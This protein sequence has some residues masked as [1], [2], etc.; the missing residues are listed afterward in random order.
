[1]LAIY[2]IQSKGCI[3]IRHAHGKH[4]QT[5]EINFNYYILFVVFNS[6]VRRHSSI[7]RSIA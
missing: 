7:T 4:I 5:D 6:I 3:V 2:I 1:M